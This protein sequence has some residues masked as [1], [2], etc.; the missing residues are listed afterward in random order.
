MKVSNK[1][2]S[3]LADTTKATTTK[4]GD[5]NE[6]NVFNEEIQEEARSHPMA[7]VIEDDKPSEVNVISELKKKNF[8]YKTAKTVS[9]GIEVYKTLDK[10]GIKI[11]VLF[12]DI[13]LKDKSSGIEFLKTIRA[14]HWME[15]TFIIVMSSL[16]DSKVVN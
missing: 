12:L 1:D 7:L 8:L 5:I 3:S 10:Q 11:D 13:V 6:E 15:N 4:I 2:L 14:N 16:E 9:E